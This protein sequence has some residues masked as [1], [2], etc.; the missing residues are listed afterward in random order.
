[1]IAITVKVFGGLRDEF[2]TAESRVEL[3]P[4]SSLGALLAQIR[5]DKPAFGQRLDE[6][7][8]KGYLNILV[9]G[10]NARFLDGM[11]TRLRDADIAAFL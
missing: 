6:G 8:A 11:D 4:G 10:R 9:N 2:G 1:M 5:R 7:L 3:A